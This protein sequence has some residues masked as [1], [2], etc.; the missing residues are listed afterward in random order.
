MPH[1]DQAVALMSTVLGRAP[2]HADGVDVWWH[3]PDALAQV[4]PY[5]VTGAALAS[6][7][8]F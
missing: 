8:A 6:A 1:R 2:E 4:D 5:S 7:R 3:V